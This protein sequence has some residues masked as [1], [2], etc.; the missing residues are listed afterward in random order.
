MM[1][2][3]KSTLSIMVVFAVLLMAF[4]MSISQAADGT[5][6]SIDFDQTSV[7]EDTLVY[8]HFKALTV[9]ADYKVHWDDGLSSYSWTTGSSQT[10]IYIPIV[11]STTDGAADF[12][13]VLEYQSAGTDIDSITVYITEVDTILDDAAFLT[14]A[15]PLIVI[16]L[17]VS[18]VVGLSIRKR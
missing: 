14:I 13:I 18:I 12:I 4:P 16:A 6:G 2:M 15:V 8:V 10:D 11:F 3:R 9:S 1:N 7:S 17:I 5:T